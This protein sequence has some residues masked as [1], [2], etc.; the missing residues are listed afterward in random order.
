MIEFI[1]HY[2]DVHRCKMKLI[3]VVPEKKVVWQVLDNYFS[4]TKDKSEWKGTTIHFEISR[5]DNKTQLRFIHQGLVSEYECFDICSNAWTD[6]IQNSL[7]KLIVTGRGKPNVDEQDYQKIISIH[8]PVNL[9]VCCHY[10][11]Y[12]GLVE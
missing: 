4:F 8:K 10:G 12:C 7:R 2:K 3:E 1:Y 11:T 5:K 6:Y 9:C